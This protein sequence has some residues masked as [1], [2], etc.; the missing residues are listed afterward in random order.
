MQF[1]DVIWQRAAIT[2]FPLFHVFT[3]SYYPKWIE[4]A[5]KNSSEIHFLP[6]Q[7]QCRH[8]EVSNTF[9]TSLRRSVFFMQVASNNPHIY[10]PPCY[11][12]ISTQFFSLFALSLS[13]KAAVATS[14]LCQTCY[15]DS[16]DVI[17]DAGALKED[18]SSLTLASV[19]KCFYFWLESFLIQSHCHPGPSP[20]SSST[21]LPC[22]V[23]IT[24]SCPPECSQ[25]SRPARHIRT[26]VA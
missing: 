23:Q 9:A 3:C 26:E 14:F 10:K 20:V 22:V 15:F 18:C 12:T 1:G 11:I 19:D 24:C 7:L 5:L 21:L 8:Q 17:Q 16:V 25:P 13:H 6:T 4:V 2:T